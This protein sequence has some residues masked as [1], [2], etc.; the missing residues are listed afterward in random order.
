[1]YLVEEISRQTIQDVWNQLL[2]TFLIQIYN[3]GEQKV[4]QKDIKTKI[5][6]SQ[7]KGWARLHS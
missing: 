2:V 6:V 7:R 4:K 1:M 5:V 3:A